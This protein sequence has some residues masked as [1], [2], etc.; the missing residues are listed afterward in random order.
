[1]SLPI[2]TERLLL[3]SFQ[4]GDLAAFQSY[5]CDPEV[6][7]FQSWDDI[8]PAEAAAFLRSHMK[9]SLGTL[10]TWQQL[11]L[12]L[13]PSDEL[14]GD[15]GFCFSEDGRSAELGFTVARQYGGRG[16]AQEALSSLISV[17]FARATLDRLDAVTDARNA[18][19]MRLLERLGFEV[20]A[21]A[22]VAFKGA[23]CTEHTYT[24][25]RSTWAA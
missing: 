17:L 14:I 2:A 9:P 20:R 23:V 8:T 11:A 13:D 24:L 21:S 16:L 18:P 19:A 15:I 10:G 7:R 12:A 4:D 25:T 3:R 5:R 22:E 6:A 1:M